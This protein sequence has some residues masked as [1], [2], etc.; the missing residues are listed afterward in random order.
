MENWIGIGIW[1]VLG[2]LIGLAMK[3][4]VRRPSE[5]RG[6]TTLLVIFGALGAVIGGMLGVGL[7]HFLHP[8]ALSPGGFGGAVFLAALLTWTYRWGA[9]A[10]A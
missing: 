6:H 2:A 8:S 3:V 10:L 9:R 4:L 5:T 1:L 7:F